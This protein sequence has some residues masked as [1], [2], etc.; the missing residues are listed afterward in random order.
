MGIWMIKGNKDYPFSFYTGQL[1][2]MA[3]NYRQTDFSSM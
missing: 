2:I 3:H 1:E